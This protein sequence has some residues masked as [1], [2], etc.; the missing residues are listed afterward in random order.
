MV[1]NSIIVEMVENFTLAACALPV[2]LLGMWLSTKSWAFYILVLAGSAWMACVVSGPVYNLWLNPE[3]GT[4]M[5]V[6]AWTIPPIFFVVLNIGTI[7]SIR[8]MRIDR[9]VQVHE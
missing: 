8:G 3:I 4:A 2:I 7:V 6:M 9:K 5:K 1:D